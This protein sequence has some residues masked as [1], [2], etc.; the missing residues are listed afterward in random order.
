MEPCVLYSRF[1]PRPV[2]DEDEEKARKARDEDAES[3]RVQKFRL[4]SYCAMKEL[5]IQ[6]SFV[7]PETSARKVA[8]FDRPQGR[9][10]FAFVVANNI[11]HV[12]TMKIDR[13]FRN[14]IDGLTTMEKFRAMGVAV[15]FADDGGV[16]CNT[17]SAKGELVFTMLLAVAAHEPRQTAERTSDALQ[18]HQRTGRRVSR[19]AAFGW[20]LDPEDNSKTIPVED[21]QALI[22]LITLR[23]ED[24]DSPKEIGRRSSR[25]TNQAVQGPPQRASRCYYCCLRDPSPGCKNR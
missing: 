12:V 5:S 15:H 19:R 7:D 17:N 10:L 22:N 6:G 9:E 11:K 2:D 24:G 1:S 8:F 21:E 16:S 18:F 13:M 3:I 25:H 14:T 23:S 20:K 4:E